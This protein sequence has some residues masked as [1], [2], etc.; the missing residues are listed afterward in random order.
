MVHNQSNVVYVGSTFNQLKKRW[1]QH[2]SQFK[3]DPSEISI[4]SYFKKHGIENFK[5]VLIKEYEVSSKNLQDKK[6][7]S[8]YETLWI[9]KLNA[10]NKLEPCSGLLKKTMF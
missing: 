4:Y 9:K 1:A 10:I 2:K 6:H 8:V 3:T 7:L 5:I